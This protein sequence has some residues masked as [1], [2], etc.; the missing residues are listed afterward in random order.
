MSPEVRSLTADEAGRVASL[1]AMGAQS[2]DTILGLSGV[3]RMRQV[4]VVFVDASVADNTL[5]ELARYARQGAR[6]YRV[7]DLT[8]I[9]TRMGRQDVRVMAI[10]PGSLATGLLKKLPTESSGDAD[11]TD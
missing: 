4:R 9:T 2:G 3:R 1:V 5:S 6:V 11:V 8:S 7:E 10:K